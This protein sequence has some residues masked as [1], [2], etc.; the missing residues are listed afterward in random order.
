MVIWWFVVV[1]LIALEM[2]I[3]AI[4][5]ISKVSNLKLLRFLINRDYLEN[6]S[7]IKFYT[8]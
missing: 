8:F 6:P 3:V 5:W 4:F 2:V 1:R 7:G